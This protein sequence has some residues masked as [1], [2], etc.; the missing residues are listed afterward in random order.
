MFSNPS[1]FSSNLLLWFSLKINLAALGQKPKIQ[2]APLHA[3]EPALNNS[4][5]EKLNVHSSVNQ[6]L[7]EVGTGFY[8]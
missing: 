4:Q 7:S 6:S 8:F 2:T 5:S 1:L 3:L